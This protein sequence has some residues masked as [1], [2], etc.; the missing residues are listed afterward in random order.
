[1]SRALNDFEEKFERYPYFTAQETFRGIATELCVLLIRW[2]NAC[3]GHMDRRSSTAISDD[4]EIA[5]VLEGQLSDHSRAGR[6]PR[7]IMGRYLRILHH[8]DEE[9]IRAHIS[10]LLPT[11]DRELSQAA[12]RSHLMNDAGPIGALVPELVS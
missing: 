12:W 2:L 11:N 4:P 5:R 10:E 8:N 6:I 3:F 9:W 7:A 1:M